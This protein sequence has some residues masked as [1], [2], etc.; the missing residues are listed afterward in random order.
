MFLVRVISVGLLTVIHLGCYAS[1]LGGED[2]FDSMESRK[3][4][5]AAPGFDSPHLHP[6]DDGGVVVPPTTATTPPSSTTTATT[7][8]TT[9]TTTPS[10]LYSR[11]EYYE[12]SPRVTD[13]QIELDMKAV[14]GVYGPAT[15]RKHI[16]ALGGPSVAV[17]TF[18]PEVWQNPTPCSHGCLPGNE[19]YEL[20]TLGELINE[21]FLPE[22]RELALKIAFCESSGRSWDIGSSEVSHAF[23]VG[24]FQHLAKYWPERSEKAG[25]GEYHPFHGR[26]NVGVA[27]WLFY[28]SGVH[29]WNPSKACWGSS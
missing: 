14:D 12:R 28:S 6:V 24:W 27:S 26:A 4:T 20:P 17:L 16:D 5:H 19:H 9:T 22:D 3:R 15:R 29:H 23:A 10:A 18:Y 11:Y 1:D 13:L 2:G 7:T 25:W 21:Y 8:T